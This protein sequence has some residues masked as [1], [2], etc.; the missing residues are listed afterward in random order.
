MSKRMKKRGGFTLVELIVVVAILAVLAV[1][2]IMAIGGVRE[3]AEKS[4][5]DANANTVVRTLNT[6]NILAKNP[7]TDSAGVNAI[8][9]DRIRSLTLNA[10]TGEDLVD[11]FIGVDIS[12]TEL[13]K[14]LAVIDYNAT[15]KMWS[16][17]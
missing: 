11:L 2:A 6:Y 7:I 9:A 13:T 16:R 3:Q 10:S 15:S 1:T 17:K 5:L 8:S 14:V 12:A 4:A